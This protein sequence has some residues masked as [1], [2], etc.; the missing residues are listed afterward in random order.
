MALAGQD[1]QSDTA[2]AVKDCTLWAI[3][4][5]ALATKAGVTLPAA[6]ESGRACRRRPALARSTNST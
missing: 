5:A 3:P 4:R 2:E 6:D 1:Q